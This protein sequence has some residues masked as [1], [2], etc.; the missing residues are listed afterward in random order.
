MNWKAYMRNTLGEKITL[1]LFGESHGEEIGC[2][3]DGLPAGLI[4][5]EQFIKEALSKRRPGTVLDTA[6]IEKDNYRIVSG[7]FN[8]YTTGSPICIIIKNENVRSSDY[9]DNIARPNH[10]DYVAYEKY[11]GFNDYRGGGHFSGRLTAPIVAQGAICLKTLENKG[12][13]IGRA[14]V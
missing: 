5:D 3:L 11:H 14:H 10:A 12:I 1:T 13:K 2:V 8:G 9:Q 6:R 7:V 4:V